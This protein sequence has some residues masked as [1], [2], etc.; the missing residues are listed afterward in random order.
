MTWVTIDDGMTD[1]P[2]VAQLTDAAFRLQIHALCYCA[3]N[4]TDGFIPTAVAV[5]LHE[6]AKR[7]I[8]ELATAGI[9]HAVDGGYQIHD[10]DQYQESRATVMQRRDATA[11]RVRKWRGNKGGDTGSN[12]VTNTGSNGV[13]TRTPQPQPQPQP[14]DLTPLNPLL[15]LAAKPGL[16]IRIKQGNQES[17][18]AAQRLL[19]AI[20]NA[21]EG[22]AGR[23]GRAL[24]DGAL[25]AD[26][27]DALQAIRVG[28]NRNPAAVACKIVEDH[29]AE[30]VAS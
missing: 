1:H 15:P 8:P 2:K 23:L 3:R 14:K 18:T 17:I 28:N 24:K 4:L 16:T 7:I 12:A 5:R 27:G 20:P 13:S 10:Y 29:I 19:E 30:R 22:T 9:W 6:R 25:P 21:T 11:K 26:F